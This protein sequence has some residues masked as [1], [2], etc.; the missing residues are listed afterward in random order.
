MPVNSQGMKQ[1]EILPAEVWHRG[2]ASINLFLEW[3]ALRRGNL[4]IT[5][6]SW[7]KII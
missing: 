4:N 6:A 3:K 5:C 1:G 2:V 7:L